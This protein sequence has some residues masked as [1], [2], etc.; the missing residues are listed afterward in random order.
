MSGLSKKKP[1]NKLLAKELNPKTY[2]RKMRSVKPI[3]TTVPDPD[4]L[5]GSRANRKALSNVVVKHHN[6]SERPLLT[7][8][9]KRH[10]R[11]HGMMSGPNPRYHKE[12]KLT[13]KEHTSYAAFKPTELQKGTLRKA[14]AIPIDRVAGGNN[15][16]LNL[17]VGGKY[18]KKNPRT[19]KRELVVQVD[20]VVSMQDR[21]DANTTRML[22][23]KE[24]RL[25][26]MAARTARK[27]RGPRAGAG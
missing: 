25:A 17:E 16:S 1:R 4:S 23:K 19:G 12:Q 9:A 18:L 22:S 20:E 14:D 26:R 3:G 24:K 13:H 2:A 5:P 8:S 6:A 21:K 10:P 27:T 15:L 11:A 7:P